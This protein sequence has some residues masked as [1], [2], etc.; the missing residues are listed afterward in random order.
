MTGGA[1]NARVECGG[2]VVGAGFLVAPRT[3]LTCAHVVQGSERAPLTVSFPGRR[4]LLSVPATVTVHGGWAGGATDPGDLA[5]LELDRALPMRPAG[6]APPGAEQGLPA[7][8]LEAYGFPNGYGEGQIAEYRA[9]SA[10][11]IADEWVQLEAVTAHGQP[12]APGFSGAAVTLK[13]G[14]VVGMVAQVAGEQ[15]VR[16]A[17]MLPVAVMARYWTGLSELVPARAGGQDPTR[18]LYGL[19]RRAEADGLECSPDRLFMDAVGDFGPA[20]PPG[21]FS[22]LRKAVGYVQWE[23][24]QPAEALARFADRLERL[25]SAAHAPAP[26]PAPVP[27]SW[28][29]ILVELDRSGAGADQVTVEVSA[30]RDGRRRPVGAVRLPRARVRS[31]VQEC[32]DEAFAHLTPGADELITFV[33]PRE[34]LNEPV[35]HWECGPEDSTPLGC[36]HPVVVADRFRHRSG[37][38]RHQLGKKW[39]KSTTDAAG[40]P[41]LHRVDC[42][43]RENQAGLRKRLREEETELAG[44]ATPPDSAPDRFE[45]GLTTPVPVLLWPRTGCPGTDHAAPCAGT[46]FLDGLA[47]RLEG[48]PPAEIP[49]R[50]RELREEVAAEE[51]PSRHWARDIQL[52]WDDPRCFPAPAASLHSPVA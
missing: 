33:L 51:D 15:G 19:V 24:E 36:A 30:Y 11:L 44:Y 47:P 52:L 39:E 10:T 9:V 34:W 32:V 29:P 31:Y 38:L 37:R 7:P 5:V 45:A 26:A 14:R 50:I 8:A 49:R 41:V 12:L 13:D 25:L 28:S 40:S 16:V 17:R 21:G 43:S 46:A 42:G 27:V 1:W 2:L 23:V 35:A 22:S 20:L 3:V 6:F 18:R 4:D 48:V